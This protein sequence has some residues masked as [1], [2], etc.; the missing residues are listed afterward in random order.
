MNIDKQ[1]RQPRLHTIET[2][3]E[4]ETLVVVTWSPRHG[5]LHLVR[6]APQLRGVPVPGV[7][8]VPRVEAAHPAARGEGGAGVAVELRLA[9]AALAA[10][11]V[12]A[13]VAGP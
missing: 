8:V 7:A 12:A 5:G 6:G 3:I 2:E 10:V 9:V 13:V 1:T 4:L 11:G